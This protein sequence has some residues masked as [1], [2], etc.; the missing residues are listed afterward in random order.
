MMIDHSGTLDR[1]SREINRERH[2]LH[3][4]IFWDLLKD[5]KYIEAKNFYNN[6]S[7]GQHKIFCEGLIMGMVYVDNADTN[8]IEPVVK[9]MDT[10]LN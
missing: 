5:K 2:D 4:Q 6:I 8:W 3:F 10:K 7:L 1:L 9:R